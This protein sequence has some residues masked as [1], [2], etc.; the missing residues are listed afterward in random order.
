MFTWQKQTEPAQHTKYFNEFRFRHSC[1]ASRCNGEQIVELLL[2]PL[3]CGDSTVQSNDVCIRANAKNVYMEIIAHSNDG[4]PEPIYQN[5]EWS[6]RLK[7]VLWTACVCVRVCC[8]PII[9][10]TN[11]IHIKKN[12]FNYHLCG[13]VANVTAGAGIHTN[14]RA[15]GQCSSVH[16]RHCVIVGRWFCVAPCEC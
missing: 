2:F 3:L 15:K 1:K 9:Y 16:N 13:C 8:V 4:G 11:Q 5:R 6:V 10:I 12:N 14:G 7:S